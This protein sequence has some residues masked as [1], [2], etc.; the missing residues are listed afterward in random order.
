MRELYMKSGAGFLLVFSLTSPSSLA[1]L[2]TLHDQLVAIKDDPAV[3]VVLVGNKLDLEDARCVC[4]AKAFGLARSWGEGVPYY[5]TSAKRN[6]NVTD[7][8]VDVCRQVMRREAA[9]RDVG[10]RRRRAEERMDELEGRRRRRR[11]GKCVI[12]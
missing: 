11:Q 9:R 1:E 12:L 10:R 2:S 5:E 7:V 8:F 4:R 3:P 6:Q